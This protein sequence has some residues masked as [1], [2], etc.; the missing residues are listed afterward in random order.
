MK[1][2]AISFITLLISVF[3]IPL[4]A[5][6]EPV[7]EG[8]LCTITFGYTGSMQ[9][10]EVPQGAINLSFEIY[11]ASGARGGGG[12]SVTGNLIDIPD[13]LYIFVGGAGNQGVTAA[14]GYNGGGRAGGNRG[15]EGALVSR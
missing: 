9:T 2:H 15:N 14:G 1:K 12:G 5:N 6:A 3:L 8:N 4:P 13:N 7:C 10:W 11:G